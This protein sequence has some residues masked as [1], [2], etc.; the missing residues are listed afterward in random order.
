VRSALLSTPRTASR[1]GMEPARQSA[2]EARSW[3]RHA[4]LAAYAAPV[5]KGVHEHTP[6]QFLSTATTAKSSYSGYL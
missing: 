5:V 1:I 3:A 4:P 6:F 2:C